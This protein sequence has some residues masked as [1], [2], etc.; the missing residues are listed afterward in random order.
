M[1]VDAM[2]SLFINPDMHRAIEVATGVRAANLLKNLPRVEAIRI[3]VEYVP[4][5]SLPLCALDTDDRLVDAGRPITGCDLFR[6]TITEELLGKG[7][8][9]GHR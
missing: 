7:E 4:G 3:G 6:V 8:G 2:P 5:N 9:V 1:H